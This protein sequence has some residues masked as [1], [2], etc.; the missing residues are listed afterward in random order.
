MNSSTDGFGVGIPP[1]VEL[2][3][4]LRRAAREYVAGHALVP[5]LS[6]DEVRQHAARIAE[7]HNAAEFAD[8]LAV[9]VGGESWRETIAALPYDRRVLLLPQCLRSTA[10]CQAEVDAFGLVCEQCGNCDLGRLQSEAEALGYVVLI[11]EGTTVVSKLLE[12]GRVDAV[13]GIS[14]LDALERSFPHLTSSAIPGIAV[15][16]LQD[17]CKDTT[18]D[19]GWVLE[20][21]RM[22]SQGGVGERLP[23]DEVKHTVN[24]WFEHDSLR[25][26]LDQG[27][28]S[29]EALALD[30]LALDGK[31]WRPF[32]TACTY[33]ALTQKD[34]ELPEDVRRAAVAVECFHKASL[35]HDDIEDDDDERYGAPTLHCRE[36]VPLALNTGDLLL[37]EGYRLLANAEASSGIRADTLRIAAEGHRTLCLGQGEELAWL[38][39]PA[40][41]GV[42]ETLR[43]FRRKTAPA[44]EVALLLGA[45]YAGADAETR[46]V[47]SAYSAA[48]G[49][50][51]QI[52]DD[53]HDFQ[54]AQGDVEARRP[55][56]VLAL[57]HQHANAST[58]QRIA[59]L[60]CGEARNTDELLELA[61]D[62]GAVERTSM[63]LEHHRN[64]A[65]RSLCN[66]RN[67]QL[68]SLLH[69]VITRILDRVN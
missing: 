43:I 41:L 12:Q 28:T 48:L 27:D 26:L 24:T 60:W 35:V 7:A 47:L 34:R 50:A 59:E 62:A 29:S 39:D 69:R 30:W 16:L 5:P 67:S 36:G 52:R 44:F 9:L 45:T 49:V 18:V 38:R 33:L 11:A 40:P 57:A 42:E 4:T 13:I 15:P 61:L 17:G 58:S 10:R 14:C 22:R 1:T 2:R 65:V 51:Y 68:K 37:G 32:L 3:E 19:T 63:L 6:Y 20:L 66:L 55:S 21:I 31:R 53:L 56:I 64:E 25:A 46:R 54:V 23:L 8:F